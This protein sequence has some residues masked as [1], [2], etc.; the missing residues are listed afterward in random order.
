[1]S[2]LKDFM[3]IVNERDHLQREK[4]LLEGQL[5][6]LSELYDDLCKYCK[7]K[8]PQ[9]MYNWRRWSDEKEIMKPTW[10]YKSLIVPG[11]S[12]PRKFEFESNV[13]KLELEEE[14]MPEGCSGCGIKPSSTGKIEHAHNC[15]VRGIG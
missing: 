14:P 12:P 6:R 7:E 13:P 2:K 8:D 3:R 4:I 10:D 1:M 11:D 5:K 9:F 15:P